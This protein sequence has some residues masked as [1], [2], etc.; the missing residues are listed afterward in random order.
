[1]S[2]AYERGWRRSFVWAGFP[3]EEK[4]YDLAM[5]YL[6]GAFGEVTCGC[7]VVVVRTSPL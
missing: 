6:Q 2:F 1:M 5:E 7:L 4:E 3:G